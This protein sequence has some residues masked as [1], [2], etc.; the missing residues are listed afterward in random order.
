MLIGIDKKSNIIL[1]PLGRLLDYTHQ[2]MYVFLLAG[3][4][5]TLSAILIAMGNFLFIKKKQEGPEA[6]MEMAVTAAEQEK[7]NHLEEHDKEE[8][9]EEELQGRENGKTTPVTGGEV[10]KMVKEAEKE[11]GEKNPETSL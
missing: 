3:C 2:Y 6:K 5:V 7:L 9:N 4:E 8:E 1:S 10:T 11:I